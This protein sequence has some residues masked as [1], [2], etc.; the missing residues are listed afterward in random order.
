M[1]QQIVGD[2]ANCLTTALNQAIPA[3]VDNLNPMAKAKAGASIVGGFLH[4]K[5]EPGDSKPPVINGS[6]PSTSDGPPSTLPPAA[7]DPAYSEVLKLTTYLAALSSI[8][9]GK[10]GNI[11]WE[12]AKGDGTGQGAKS[13]IKFLATMLGDAKTRFGRVATDAQPSSS[14]NT[15]LDTCFRVS[16]STCCKDLG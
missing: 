16:T 4:P 8:V 2:L 12:M 3:L 10:D 13:S 6:S 14:M 1:G 9:V 5:A 7:A 15:I 11:N